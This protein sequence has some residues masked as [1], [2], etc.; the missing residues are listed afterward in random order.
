MAN[1]SSLSIRVESGRRPTHHG[2]YPRPPR[3]PC[4]QVL[5]LEWPDFVQILLEFQ[6]SFRVTRFCSNFT[7]T[8]ARS[9]GICTKSDHFAFFFFGHFDCFV[10]SDCFDD[11][12]L[13]VLTF[14]RATGANHCVIESTERARVL[15][16]GFEGQPLNVLRMLRL[17]IQST[18]KHL[19]SR[20][21]NSC[22]NLFE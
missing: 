9:S 3:C 18:P 22:L 10:E 1:P 16:E 21:S 7:I 5:R 6:L 15:Q 11:S 14:V 20:H 13:I 8:T 4:F 17:F 2:L 19:K 12:I